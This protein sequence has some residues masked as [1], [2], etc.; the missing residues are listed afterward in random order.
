VNKVS[1]ALAVLDQGALLDTLRGRPD[2]NTVYVMG[3]IRPDA[4]SVISSIFEAVR[5]QMAYPGSSTAWSE[6]I[7]REVQHILGPEAV[8]LLLKIPSPLPSNHVV[9]V[10]CHKVDP[11]YQMA[12]RSIIDHHIINKEFPYYVAL[13]HEV[14]W[15]STIQVYIKILGSGFEL[16]LTMAKMLLEGTRLEAEPTLLLDMSDC[17]RLAVQRLGRSPRPLP[18][19]R[20]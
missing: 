18:P 11:K 3:H 1:S 5:R 2:Q 17:D 12:V 14:S 7:P 19:I 6:S 9:L 20:I 4:D 13:S 8:E 15:S 10:D 16:S